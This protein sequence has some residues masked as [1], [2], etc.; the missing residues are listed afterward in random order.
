MGGVNFV[1]MESILISP[2]Y[3]QNSQL[4]IARYFGG[5]KVNNKYYVIDPQSNYLVDS[6]WLSLVR[7]VGIDKTKEVLKSTNDIKE[8][9]SLIKSERDVKQKD[10]QLELF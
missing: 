2:E 4:S 8:A 9:M 7:K 6:K 5:V 10:S 1:T 3:W